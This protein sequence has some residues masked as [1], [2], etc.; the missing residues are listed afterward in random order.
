MIKEVPVTVEKLVVSEVPVEIDRIV[1]RDLPVE[2]EKLVYV[3][4]PV[5]VPLATPSAL[6]PLSLSLT[7]T[8]TFSLAH[9][10]KEIP[11]QLP[12]PLTTGS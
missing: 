2:V 7:H 8:R 12:L 1:L 9:C 3:Q 6:P 4:V 5:E 11:V 10:L